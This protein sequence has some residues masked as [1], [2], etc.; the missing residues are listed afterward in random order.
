MSPV[1]T[2]PEAAVAYAG[3]NYMQATPL[4]DVDTPQT[5]I[6][7]PAPTLSR[8]PANMFN[9]PIG[10]VS[11]GEHSREILTELGLSPHEVSKLVAAGVV[12]IADDN[13]LAQAKL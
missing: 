1:L 5:Y 11:P 9:G 13:V 3:G 8:T 2:P 6:S 4:F 12:S 10:F 7:S